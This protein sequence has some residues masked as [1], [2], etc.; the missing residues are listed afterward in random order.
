MLNNKNGILRVGNIHFVVT[1]TQSVQKAAGDGVPQP[2]F[3]IKYYF[4][5]IIIKIC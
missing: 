4:C 2:V 5:L 3:L 1:R